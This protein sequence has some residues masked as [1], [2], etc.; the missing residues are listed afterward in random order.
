MASAGW[1]AVPA[2]VVDHPLPPLQIAV[3]RQ[4]GASGGPS[5]FV[6]R[7]LGA[8]NLR[9]EGDA[10]G[11]ALKVP[12]VLGHTNVRQGRV[13]VPGLTKR[14]DAWDVGVTTAI[15][16]VVVHHFLVNG[17][18]GLA[19]LLPNLH[20]LPCPWGEHRHWHKEEAIQPAPCNTQGRLVSI[21]RT[22][23]AA[24]LVLSRSVS[25]C[26]GCV[27]MQARCVQGLRAERGGGGGSHS[28]CAD[29]LCVPYNSG[30][31]WRQVH[32]PTAPPRFA[33]TKKGAMQRPRPSCCWWSV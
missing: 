29:V 19:L 12:L 21:L 3:R 13:I 16:A 22:G 31:R 4:S 10:L 32:Y 17:A 5:G 18:C 30:R 9:L 28:E 6:A 26:V 24:V 23:F 8:P 14:L 33:R 7:L 11:T 2:V 25:R 20:T 15:E 1:G 27:R